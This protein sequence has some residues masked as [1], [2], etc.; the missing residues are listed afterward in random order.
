L[1]LEV[2]NGLEWKGAIENPRG[3]G[4]GMVWACEGCGGIK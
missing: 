3:E 1:E 2:W 4:I